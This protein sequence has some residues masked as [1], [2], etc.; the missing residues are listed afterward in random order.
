MLQTFILSLIQSLTEFLPVSSSG[1]LLLADAFGFSNQSLDFDAALHLGTLIAVVLYFYKDLLALLT[2]IWQ[3]GAERILFFQLLIATLPVLCVGYFAKYIIETALRSPLV[4]AITSICFGILLWIVDKYSL[5]TKKIKQLSYW[6]AL[7]IGLAQILALVPGTSRS[8]ITITAAR[9][10]G[11]NR[12]DSTRFS[13]LL[14]IPTIFIAGTYALWEAS[15]TKAALA[16]TTQ[17]MWGIGL[18][19][20]FGLMAVWFLMHWVK[21]ASFAVFAIYR[22]ILGVFLLYFFL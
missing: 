3:K 12:T 20:I 7:F 18:T 1:H 11:M 10:L 4:V 8:G 22:I 5:K 6:G 21:R 14:S 15:Q 19:A 17:M 16:L 13:M 2:G 9:F